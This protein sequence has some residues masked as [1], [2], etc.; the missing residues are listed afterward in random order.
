MKLECKHIEEVVN[1][2]KA[3]GNGV[4]EISEGWTK[5]KQVVHMKNKLSESDRQL[6]ENRQSSLRSWSAER[7][8]HSSAEDGY[9]C[10]ECC[11]S[12]TFPR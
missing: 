8:P 4:V 7:T 5:V 9:T 3:S 1:I 11:V 10:D 2:V 6:I 12:I